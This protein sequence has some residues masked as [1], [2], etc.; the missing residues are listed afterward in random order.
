MEPSFPLHTLVRLF[1]AKDTT[2]EKVLTLDLRLD[3]KNLTSKLAC[4]NSYAEFLIQ[5]LKSSLHKQTDPINE[6]KPQFWKHCKYC[7]KSNHCVLIC[8]GKQR[9]FVEKKRNFFS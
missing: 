7:H 1:D 5:N 2:I 8:F 4:Q 6:D 3:I 9:E